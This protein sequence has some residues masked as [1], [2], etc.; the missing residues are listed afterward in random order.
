MTAFKATLEEL[1]DA[2]LLLHIVDV[3]NPRF[4]QHIHSVDTILKEL[5]LSEKPRLLILNKIDRIPLDEAHNLSLRYNAIAISARDSLTFAPL[6]QQI[7]EHIWNR[8]FA[9]INT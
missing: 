1:K 2:H 3:S 6:L 7:E 9:E 4:E 8:H 5:L